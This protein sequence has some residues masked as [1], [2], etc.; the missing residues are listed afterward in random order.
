[1]DGTFSGVAAMDILWDELELDL[2]LLFDNMLV[3]GTGF[4]IKD[5]QVDAVAAGFE[6][7][8]DG[9]VGGNVVGII[10]GLEWGLEDCIGVE[11]LGNHNVLIAAARANG[12]AAGVFCVQLTNM[13]YAHMHFIGF[14]RWD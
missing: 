4:V 7:F 12:G 14:D 13:L 1:M 2:T 5:L 11:V 9:G 3:L 6:A 8:H 10:L